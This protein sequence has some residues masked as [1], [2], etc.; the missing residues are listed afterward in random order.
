MATT[1]TTYQNFVKFL[2][3]DSV[4]NEIRYSIV[5][6]G[7]D[8]TDIDFEYWGELNSLAKT[9]TEIAFKYHPERLNHDND[10]PKD[11]EAAKAS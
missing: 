10:T 3:I 6:K 11:Q 8:I 1:V 2:D 5:Q 9:I 7:E 4:I